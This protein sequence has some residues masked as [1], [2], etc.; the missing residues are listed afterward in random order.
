MKKGNDE[1]GVEGRSNVDVYES[2]SSPI[3]SSGSTKE[4]NNSS[5]DVKSGKKRLPF[6]AKGSQHKMQYPDED[7][8]KS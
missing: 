2:I 7:D 5:L 1:V 4:D 6:C 8:E 3:K